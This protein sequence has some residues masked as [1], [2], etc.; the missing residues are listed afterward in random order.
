MRIRNL[1]SI[2]ATLLLLFLFTSCDTDSATEPGETEFSFNHEINPGQSAPEFLTDENFER[3][4]VQVQYMQGYEPTQQG[5]NNLK[6]FLSN[7]LNKT[8]I[9]IMEPEEIPASGES[10]YTA[11]DIRDLEREHRTQFSS[12]NE[13]VAYFIVVDGEFSDADVLGIAHFNTS[14]ALFG[15][16]FD[17]VSGGIGSPPKEDVE[18][19]VMQ[20]EFG[21]ILG[22]VN[23]GVDMQNNHQDTENGRHCDNE[24]CLMNYAFRN[25]NL[26]AN[27]FGGYIPELDENCVA[28]LQAAG[29]K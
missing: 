13:I 22:L 14:M 25:A 24:E 29:G 20:H 2:T 15:P 3:L 11:N 18:T 7:R 10:S 1:L 8:S 21:H 16:M 9:T 27:I 26:F 23:N 4:V 17:E 28:D 6:T 19:I 12:E 5:L